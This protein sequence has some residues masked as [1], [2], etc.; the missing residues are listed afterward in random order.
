MEGRPKQEGYVQRSEQLLKNLG[1]RRGVK[2]HLIKRH[3]EDNSSVIVGT[4]LEGN[5]DSDVTFGNSI[6]IDNNTKSTSRIE[7]VA[8]QDGRI[9]L[10]TETSVYE[11]MRSQERAERKITYADLQ[12]EFDIFHKKGYGEWDMLTNK[13]PIEDIPYQQLFVKNGLK[14]GDKVEF[15]AE[16]ARHGIL[17]AN[18]RG[19]IT[20]C[21]ERGLAWGLIGILRGGWLR[22]VVD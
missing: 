3:A 2:I 8:E 11:L 10:K 21:D 4:S 14:V 1:L 19:E 9:F 7:D 13:V 20:I 17:E 22:K 5:L 12:R 18:R 16:K 15:Y 6:S